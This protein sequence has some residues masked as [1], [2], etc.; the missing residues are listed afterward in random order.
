MRTEYNRQHNQLGAEQVSKEPLRIIV[1]DDN[2]DSADT[3]AACLRLRDCEVITVYE[4]LEIVPRAVEFTP[5]L[6]FLD[7]VMP[8]L[9]GYEVVRQLRATPS[10][11]DV[12]IVALTGLARADD[13]IRGLSAG[14]DG[15]LVKP[16]EAVEIYRLIDGLFKP[17]AE[18]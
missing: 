18:R 9:D 13:K 4:A 11:S 17:S 12:K 7:I 15:Y 10:V 6:V 16:T 3:M 5:H 8:K 14:F 1:A 2:V